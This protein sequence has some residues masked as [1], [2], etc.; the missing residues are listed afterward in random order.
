MNSSPTPILARR[1]SCRGNKKSLDVIVHDI[2]RRL[3]GHG[4]AGYISGN[5]PY[6]FNNFFT[7][8]VE[9]FIPVFPARNL[10][11]SALL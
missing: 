2:Y 6:K 5:R 1:I 3:T 9:Q 4:A 7:I 11:F 8:F 10:L